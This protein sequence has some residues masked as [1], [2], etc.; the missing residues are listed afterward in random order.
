M[1]LVQRQA[2]KQAVL[3]PVRR[4]RNAIRRAPAQ[5]L[6]QEQTVATRGVQTS[7]MPALPV[8]GWR[9]LRPS[10]GRV[11]HL[12]I[13]AVNG[14][15]LLNT[16]ALIDSLSV[17]QQT[18]GDVPLIEFILVDNGS[19]DITRELFHSLQGIRYL[20]LDRTTTFGLAANA[21]WP[22]ALGDVLFFIEPTLQVDPQFLR[23]CLPGMNARTIIGAQLRGW[24]GFLDAAG[25]IVSV[26]HGLQGYGFG[27]SGAD[28]RFLFARTVDYCPGIF[29]LQRETL[30]RL[31]G[32]TPDYATFEIAAVDV[33]MRLQA[34]GGDA[35]YWPPAVASDWSGAIRLADTRIPIDDE[36]TSADWRRFVE[37][38]HDHMHLDDRKA[39]LLGDR[40]RRQ[41]L[42]FVD[43]V[44]PEPDLNAGSILSL[45]LMRMLGD[46]GFRVTFVPES[47]MTFAG[48]Y[49]HA[50]Q[51]LGIDA[52]YWPLCHSLDELLTRR[53]HE[54][55]V[56]VLCRATIAGR[57]IEK[58]RELAP[59]ARIVFN[60]I[61]LHFMREMREAQLRNDPEMLA[62][63]RRTETIEL[64]AVA[65]TDATIVVSSHEETILRAAVPNARVHVVP[66]LF[67]MPE[68]LEAT[69]PDNRHDIMFVGT[70]QHPPNADAA[71][72]FAREIWP[73][74][75]PR[76]P[77]ARFL[78][79]GS[80]MTPEVQALAGDGIEVL[81]YVEDLD[82]T[83][84]SCRLTVAPLRFG[85]GLKGKVASS[86]LAG[87]PV[88]ATPIAVEGTTMRHG[89]EVMIAEDPKSFAEAVVKVY[90]DPVLW[91]QLAIEGFNFV[92]REYA[93]DANI[94]R[95]RAVLEDAGV[96][97][98]VAPG[99][100]PARKP[101][102]SETPDPAP[103]GRDALAPPPN[104]PLL[105]ASSPIGSQLPIDAS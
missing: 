33:A 18:A 95:V 26:T 74:L 40:S 104:P 72:W 43:A 87:V 105:R 97:L 57:Y 81:G 5:I 86:Q 47:N 99:L 88:V 50:L 14:G 8:A 83:F 38:N 85:A 25:G 11:P 17:A 29:G 12:S 63:A 76:L 79:V 67:D 98:P 52:V 34:S 44:T 48:P 31:G 103:T 35:V 94:D 28:S 1:T 73:L 13:I 3:R 64:A 102:I 41:R 78:I 10:G 92:R 19:E 22:T 42:L 77:E 46:L 96:T 9:M 32:F 24:D 20:R 101:P 51:A 65:Q 93:M 4:V 71:I 66:L 59:R 39:N 7:A 45:N 69:G 53:G 21:A 30:A 49:T 75:R 58:T 37:R 15:T 61:D 70:Y 23:Q 82:A 89:V 90:R 91:R 56:V 62:A 36:V 100:V 27:Q 68:Q 2:V 16:L 84:A 55:D 80:S 6:S 54:F 60:T